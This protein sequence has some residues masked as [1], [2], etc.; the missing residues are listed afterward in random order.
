MQNTNR[1]KRRLRFYVW[2]SSER[3]VPNRDTG[4]RYG[5]A[6]RSMVMHASRYLKE[7]LEVNQMKKERRKGHDIRTKRGGGSYDEA[8]R[9]LSAPERMIKRGNNGQ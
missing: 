2:R 5:D 7:T 1:Q 3:N 6:T 8:E 4:W 9:K